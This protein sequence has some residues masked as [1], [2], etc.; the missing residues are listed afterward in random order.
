MAPRFANLLALVGPEREP[1]RMP[2]EASLQS[3]L[4]QLFREQATFLRPADCDIVDFTGSYRPDDPDEVLA[5][6]PFVL[7]GPLAEAASAPQGCPRFNVTSDIADLRGFAAVIRGNSPQILFQVFDRRRVID[8]ARSILFSGSTFSRLAESGVMV[9]TGLAVEYVDGNLFF[10]SF[11]AA[12]RVLDLDAYYRQATSADIEEFLKLPT[13]HV[14]DATHLRKS[15]PWARHRLAQIID[16]GVLD[17]IDPST[18]V[19]RATSLGIS[20]STTMVKGRQRIVVPTDKRATKT[21]LQFLAEDHFRGAL[22]G[23]HFMSSSK[24]VVNSR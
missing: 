19:E 7:P 6:R 21:L 16:S 18:I 4:T 2:L 23:T 22:T 10:R 20:V 9:D 24:R 15:G 3:D 13:I 8:R 5:I 17:R 12:S 1:R 14:E 11:A